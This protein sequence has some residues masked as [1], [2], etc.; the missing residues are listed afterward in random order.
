MKEKRKPMYK[1]QTLNAISDIIH[2]Q[3]SADQYTVSGISGTVIE[4]FLPSMLSIILDEYAP[5][6]NRTGVW[7]MGLGMIL[8]A[9]LAWLGNCIANRMSTSITRE[10]TRTLRR[11]LFSRI[12]AL[13]AAQ[14]DR[15]T[16]ASLISRLTSD[17]YN[18][19]QLL[20]RLQRLGIRAP[21][22][23]IGGI[24]G[25]NVFVVLLVGIFSGLIITLASGTADFMTVLGGMG[26]GTT[27]GLRSGTSSGMG[28][29]GGNLRR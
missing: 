9:F 23:L 14:Q 17:T 20:A 5:V 8:C 26:G 3:L 2:T 21:I 22:L 28:G 13:S 10:I 1:I 4:L 19:N 16:D 12:T 15:L 6:G 25:L 18:V 29:M 7:V 24:V 11:D 27:G